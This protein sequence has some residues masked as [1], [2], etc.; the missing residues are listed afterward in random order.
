MKRSQFSNIHLRQL[1][2][3]MQEVEFVSAIWQESHQS[4]QKLPK[5]NNNLSNQRPFGLSRVSQKEIKIYFTK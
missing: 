4:C 1:Q 2:I 5:V 3:K